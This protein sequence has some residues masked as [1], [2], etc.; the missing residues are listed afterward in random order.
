MPKNYGEKVS[1]SHAHDALPTTGKMRHAERPKNGHVETP[2]ISKLVV[3]S[4]SGACKKLI[5]D[6]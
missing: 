4:A 6:C 1:N 2:L 3:L 5:T